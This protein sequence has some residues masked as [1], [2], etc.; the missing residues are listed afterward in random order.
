MAMKMMMLM[1][2][3]IMMVM[4]NHKSS[5]NILQFVVEAT[6]TANGVP[7]ID[8]IVS[9]MS[10]MPCRNGQLVCYPGPPDQL[11]LQP[12]NVQRCP[13]DQ[14]EEAVPSCDFDT[15]DKTVSETC[16]WEVSPGWD[17]RQK[18]DGSGLGIGDY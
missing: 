3:M 10:V 7:A 14:L 17:A 18:I 1:M 13:S 9:S 8:N 6:S 12:I 5:S 11:P 2:I 15:S 16:G 4:K